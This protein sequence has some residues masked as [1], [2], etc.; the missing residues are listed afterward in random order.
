M[1]IKKGTRVHA[2]LMTE[3]GLLLG[4]GCR[5]KGSVDSVEKEGYMINDQ[6]SFYRKVAKNT[7]HLEETCPSFLSATRRRRT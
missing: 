7:V 4:S 2:G 6:N 3:N 5:Y 1:S